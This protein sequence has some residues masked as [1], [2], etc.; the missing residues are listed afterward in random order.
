M[1][2]QNIR[3]S[4]GLFLYFIAVQLSYADEA[5]MGSDRVSKPAIQS[6]ESQLRKQEPPTLQPS[7]TY[8][9]RISAAFKRNMIYTEEISGTKAAEV[10][11]K[12]S[13]DGV[14]LSRRLTKPSGVES[15]D[16]AVLKAVDKTGRVPLDT[17]GTVPP[18]IFVVFYPT[19]YPPIAP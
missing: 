7:A 16:L 18:T 6:T 17:N 5:L 10:E 13:P 19:S 3:S 9:A 12:V 11:I 1:N 2:N 4:V 14:I 15:W 8:P